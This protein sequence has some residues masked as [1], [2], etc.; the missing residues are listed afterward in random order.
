MCILLLQC[1]YTRT[2]VFLNF[3]FLIFDTYKFVY[4]DKYLFLS[5]LYFILCTSPILHYN[6]IVYFFIPC[7]GGPL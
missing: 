2:F 6:K 1:F 5:S 4:M 7:Y 3:T